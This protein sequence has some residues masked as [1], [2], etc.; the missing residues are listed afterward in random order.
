MTQAF[1][2]YTLGAAYA[3][4]MEDRLGRLAPGHLADLV[5]LDKDPFTCGPNDLLALTSSATMMNGEW[6]YRSF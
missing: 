5:V 3:A 4:G 2:G 6:V 1:A